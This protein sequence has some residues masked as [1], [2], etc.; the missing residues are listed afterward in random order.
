MRFVILLRQ[1]GEGCDYTI[2]CGYRFEF[3]DA[4]DMDDALYKARTKDREDY[5]YPCERIWGHKVDEM[6]KA[7]I[8]PV[9]Q[10]VDA[11]R[12]KSNREKQEEADLQRRGG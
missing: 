10:M 2:G 1:H 12:T 3:F 5:N 9:D 4:K 6:D 8:L 11:L 7:L